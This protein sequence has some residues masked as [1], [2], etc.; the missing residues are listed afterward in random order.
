MGELLKRREGPGS[1]ILHCGNPAALNGSIL[2]VPNLRH[3]LSGMAIIGHLASDDVLD[4]AYEW[5][6]RR[7][8][9]YSA[10]SDVW[11]F[12]RDWAREKERIKG[13]LLPENCRFSLLLTRITLRDGEDS[14]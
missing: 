14:Q 2:F 3:D 1:T 13:E 9:E 7:R 12:R 6:F 5:L 11:A 4:A 10:N 8:R